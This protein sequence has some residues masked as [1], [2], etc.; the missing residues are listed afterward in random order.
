[1][2][3][4]LISK[5]CLLQLFQYFL[6]KELFLMTI[7]N[8]RL[9]VIRGTDAKQE[10]SLDR[11]L[12]SIGRATDNTLVLDEPDVSRHHA[13]LTWNPHGYTITDLS[14]SCGTL[15]NDNMLSPQVPKFLVNGD[16]I[17]IGTFKVYFCP[18][19]S[20]TQPF[21]SL[22]ATISPQPLHSSD[23]TVVSLPSNTPVLCITTPQGT[24][25][26]LLQ[27]DN[28]SLGRDLA[29]D[30]VIDIPVVSAKHA[31]LRRSN[32]T[33][34]IVDLNSRNGLIFRDQRI[35]QKRLNDGDVIYLDASVILTYQ[36]TASVNVAMPKQVLN[37]RGRD[38]L[39]L[40]RDLQN[41]TVID[42]P[43][44]SRFHAFIERKNS[45]IVITDLSSTNG[46][47]VNGKQI[48]RDRPLRPE[49]TIR[50]GPCRL[51]FNFDETIVRHDEEGNLRLDAINLRK[52][53]G[54][55]TTLLDDI[56]LSVLAKEF[57]VIAGVSGGGKST[58]LDALNGFRPA[59]SGSV[60]VNGTDLYKNFNAYRTE[61]GYVPQKDIV[62]TELTV[63]QAL[64]YSAQLRMPADTTLAERK[65]R[66]QEVLED[67]GLSHRRDVSVKNLS[68]GQLKRVSIGV[69]LL[70]KPSLFF[71]DEATSGLDPGTEADIMHLL[72]K[73]ADQGRTVLLITH[74]TENVVLCD[75]VV[76]LAAGGRVAYL[77]PPDEAPQHFGVTKFNEIYPK[78]E[79]ER[80]P[81]EWQ[82]QY[83]QSPQYQ[84]YVVERQAS[85]EP[86]KVDSRRSR[87]KKQAPGSKVKQISAWRQ[88]LI[89]SQRNIAILLRD[90]ASLTLM[91]AIAPILGL[92]DFF[93]WKRTMFD[94]EQGDAGQA[95]TMLFNTGLIAVMVGSLATM[96]EI[97][98]EVDIYR[99]ERMIGLMRIPYILSKIW[100]VILLAIY[101]AAVFLLFKLLAVNIPGNLVNMYI[102]LLLATVAGMMM[103]LLVSAVSPNQ[104]V[105]PLLTIIFLVPQIIFGGGV[106]PVSQFGLPGRLIN[107]ISLTK[108]PFEALVTITG[109]GT[110]VAEDSCW[111]L[112]E[113][114]RKKLTDTE[115]NKRCQCL[116]PK[117]FEKCEF[118]GL[119]IKYDDEAKAAV[120]KPE[121]AKPKSPGD[122]PSDPSAFK[123]YQDKVK[124]Y[125]KDIEVWQ[126]DFSKWK[127]KRE[128]AIG[129]AEGLLSRF[130]K[131]YGQM[132][133]VNILK[134]WGSL[135][136]IMAV[137]F[138]FLVGVHKRK[139]IT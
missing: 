50:V 88:L 101:Q 104:N 87:V 31:Q 64:D 2:T 95:I 29:S 36:L 22:D 58:L 45:V 68:G 21:A 57:V 67:L 89:L 16:V 41:D 7:L 94:I 134:H 109:L 100:F 37:L 135:S 85:V 14:S 102:T 53:V 26:V 20:V 91:L 138:S 28:L 33:Y 129:G 59:T 4:I 103:G 49:D 56:S 98:K 121:P 75:L 110:D 137:M 81:E 84:K 97:V 127:E 139:D 54:K 46:T 86:S 123:D 72:R 115:K 92:L 132:F 120:A 10:L 34:E 52:V 78:V 82:R 6:I 43:S 128:S 80:S 11:G 125:N 83:L 111:K 1:L 90:R 5:I 55:G 99:R 136:L 15:V 130:H 119:K 44:V 124:K 114:E 66:I 116:G 133:K 131:D 69:E 122:P 40:G 113:D 13:H 12:L 18:E 126:K 108:W 39:S 17:R 47:F 27:K 48:S 30:I 117:L 96:R 63:T 76:F 71:L 25:N 3:A 73:L 118:P 112:S 9:E 42:H 106:L 105:A 51:V 77:G 65:A 38:T 24:W 19:V 70:T 35:T 93:T 32:G 23:S 61:L 60:L 107:H 79:R 74:A 62:H 8:P